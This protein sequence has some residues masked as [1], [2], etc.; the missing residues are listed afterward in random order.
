MVRVSQA[1]DLSAGAKQT[2]GGE[3]VSCYSSYDDTRTAVDLLRF[4]RA[5]EPR[6]GLSK[7]ESHASHVGA[8][9]RRGRRGGGWV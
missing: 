6:A 5:W 9:A 3:G 7:S 4:G 1:E 2:P 8:G